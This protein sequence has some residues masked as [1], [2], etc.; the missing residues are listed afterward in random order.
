[1]A[2]NSSRTQLLFTSGEVSP[3]LAGRTDIA[4]VQ[5]ACRTLQNMLVNP[6]GA[7]VRRAGTQ[8][9]ASAKGSA[10]GSSDNGL[11]SGFYDS[12]NLQYVQIGSP[13]TVWTYRWTI[14]ID[15]ISPGTFFWTT[16]GFVSWTGYN[17][18][19]GAGDVWI[20][21]SPVP[22]NADG[23]LSRYWNWDNLQSYGR[24]ARNGTTAWSDS[25]QF[26][27]M[28]Q[29]YTPGLGFLDTTGPVNLTDIIS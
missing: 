18:P 12:G 5:G 9:I 19:F 26:W 17:P 4:P 14:Q 16:H 25:T 3:R 1:M 13:N 23:L 8:Y 21:T 7:A 29:Y 2:R 27:A 20:Q 28:L 11:R 6:R 22:N 24:S 10:P 15:E